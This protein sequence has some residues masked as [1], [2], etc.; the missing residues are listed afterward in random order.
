VA[1]T[2]VTLD[3]AAPEVAPAATPRPGAAPVAAAAASRIAVLASLVLIAAGVVALRDTLVSQGWVRGTTWLPGLADALRGPFTP[4]PWLVPAGA[5]LAV[6]GLIIA[7]TALTPRRTTAQACAGDTAVYVSHRDVAAA[8]ATAAG[9]VPG[10]TRSRATASRRKVTVSCR[11]TDADATAARRAVTDAV[12]EA[13]GVL[14]KTP[15]IV[16]HTRTE[17]PS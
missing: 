3:P 11:T 15:R 2:T 5:A 4:A 17:Q 16:V 7:V 9:D 6:V 10:V 13:L 12:T 14:Q 1:D 8:A